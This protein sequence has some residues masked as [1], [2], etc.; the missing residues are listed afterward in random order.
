MGIFG[1]IMKKLY[2]CIL[3]FSVSNLWAQSSNELEMRKYCNKYN[4]PFAFATI[5]LSEGDEFWYVRLPKALTDEAFSNAV[6]EK[7]LMFPMFLDI[8][9]KDI[10]PASIEWIICY[11]N[12]L[13]TNYGLSWIQVAAS[14][15]DGPNNVITE[16]ISRRAIVYA[17][18]IIKR[19]DAFDKI[20]QIRD[21]LQQ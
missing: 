13:R 10:Q 20:L 16:K 8:F 18:R 21:I 11:L 3:L 6:L 4:V 9:A 7:D 1:G 17:E 15:S 14:Y 5:I 2:L 19:T 12:Y